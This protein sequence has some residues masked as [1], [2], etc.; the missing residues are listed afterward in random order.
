[1]KKIAGAFLITMVLLVA[2]LYRPRP[3]I[4]IIREY[5]ADSMQGKCRIVEYTIGGYATSAVF[6]DYEGG[7]YEAFMDELEKEGRIKR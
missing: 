1:M 5:L 2:I 4:F 3:S 6:Y 7:R